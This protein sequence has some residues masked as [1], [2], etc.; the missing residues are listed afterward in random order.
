VAI[1][2]QAEEVKDIN[3]EVVTPIVINQE[4]VNVV[5]T[6]IV[7]N[8]EAV[9]VEAS[10]E[11]DSEVK[12]AAINKEMEVIDNSINQEV[13]QKIETKMLQVIMKMITFTMMIKISMRKINQ[14]SR[15]SILDIKST[16]QRRSQAN[17]SQ[18]KIHNNKINHQRIKKK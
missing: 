13:E 15:K 4:A 14:E 17:K 2:T 16:F 6:L 7:I 1:E 3:K 11:V 8:Q 12:E 9:N 5:V 10:K 18:I